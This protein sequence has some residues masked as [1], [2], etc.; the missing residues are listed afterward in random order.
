MDILIHTVSGMVVGTAAAGISKGSGFR[1]GLLVF[2]G[3]AAGALP[4]LDVISLWS[5]FDDSIGS[6]LGLQHSGRDIYFGKFWYSHHAITHSLFAA[7]ACSGV[8]L[9]I[10][11]LI[12]RKRLRKKDMIFPVTFFF[13]Y[14][15]HLLGDLP[16]P[17]SVWEGIQ[18]WY[19]STDYIGGWGMTW[20][21]NNYDIFLII[22]FGVV[23]NIVINLANR[24]AK[25]KLL[26]WVP[27]GVVF[28]CLVMCSYRLSVRGMS[29]NYDE[30]QEA[31]FGNF[32]ERSLEIQK[33]FL[34]PTMFEM[35]RKFD[36]SLP[37]MF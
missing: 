17:G 10:M 36:E 4:D 2:T 37:V 15:A 22:S 25:L 28:L 8:L 29:F 33:E 13:G 12:K 21:W 24:F 14:I 3:M 11:K 27:T 18:F 30:Y 1:K 23:L 5:G 20:W 34:G 6:W 26:R 32:S 16:T 7:L 31:E 19:P 35:M 9:G